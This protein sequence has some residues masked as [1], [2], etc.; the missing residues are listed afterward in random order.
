MLG[1]KTFQHGAMKGNSDIPPRRP[2]VTALKVVFWIVLGMAL[3]FAGLIVCIVRTLTPERLTPL[4]EEVANRTLDAY[5]EVDRVE[6]SFRNSYPFVDLDMTDISVLSKA[7]VNLPAEQHKYL[8]EW[9]D[10]LLT[11]GHVH[12]GINPFRLYDDI[13]DLHDLLIDRPQVNVLVVDTVLNNFSLISGSDD[14]SRKLTELPDIRLN[15]FRLVS[16][17]LIRYADMAQHTEINAEIVD[18]SLTNDSDKDSYLPQYHVDFGSEIDSPL[19]GIIGQRRIRVALDGTV[20]WRHDHPYQI[21]LRDFDIAVYRLS[22][23]LDTSIDFRNNMIIKEFDLLINPLAVNDILG[24]IPAEYAEEKKIPRRLD[25]DATVQAR[26][27]LLK[28]YTIGSVLLPWADV[29]VEIPDCHLKYDNMDFRKVALSLGIALRGSTPN[30]AVFDIRRLTVEG[31]HADLTVN[32]RVTDIMR[33]PRVEGEIKGSADVAALP[34]SL[35]SKIQAIVQ[36]SVRI[37][38]RLDARVS[39]FSAE[40]FHKIHI[41][42]DASVDRFYFQAYDTL[43]FYKLHKAS[44]RFGS[45]D[46]STLR[47][48]ADIDTA[49]MLVSG[50]NFRMGHVS[51]NAAAE[52]Y[53]ALSDK[54]AKPPVRARLNVGNFS[55]FTISDTLGARMADISG[56]ITMLRPGANPRLPRIALDMKLGQ[57]SSGNNRMRLVFGDGRLDCDMALLPRGGGRN[58]SPKAGK[59]VAAGPHR[60]M[61]T[62]SVIKFARAIRARH[63]SPFPRVHPVITGKDTEVI[64]FGASKLI[65][66]MLLNWKIR[67]QL[68]T[69]IARVFTPAFPVRN[70]IKSLAVKFDNDTISLN[71]IECRAGRSDFLVSGV[72]TNLKQGLTSMSSPDPLKINFEIKSDHIDIN[73]FAGAFFTGATARDKKMNPKAGDDELRVELD[74]EM[75]LPRD[76]VAPFLVPTN[77]DAR[78]GITA[79]K[80]DYSDMQLHDFTGLVLMSGGSINLHDCKASLAAGSVTLDALYSASTPDDMNFGFGLD[81]KDF[82]IHNFLKMMPPVDSLM[83]VMRD[84]SGV[85]NAQVAATTKITPAMKI[86]M[87]TMKAAVR[88]EGDSIVFLSEETYRE[89][90][91]WLLFKHK[92]ENMV[93]HVNVEMLIDDGS[94]RLYPFIFDFN[95]YRLGIEGYTDIDLQMHYHV[96]VLKSPIPFKFGVNLNGPYDHLKIRFG[97]AHFDEKQ[98]TERRPAVSDMRRSLIDDIQRRFTL[99][100]RDSEFARLHV[101][102]LPRAGFISL[103]TDTLSAADSLYLMR[104][105]FIPQ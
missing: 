86:D 51:L 12:G 52:D 37:D 95:R 33:D 68:N 28:P 50:L 3:A 85:V 96:A 23:H 36:G 94:L 8:P 27:H 64:D 87:P 43:S 73:E 82:N 89:V 57:V 61:P 101:G 49:Q 74:E 22:G 11:I 47:V 4:V 7:I 21:S 83:P 45:A 2:W 29:E 78:F 103:E 48:A 90:A 58:E 92:D 91:K 20:E 9:A 66:N 31:P 63:H 46:D 44:L 93:R 100:E 55:L 42:G 40:D 60:V 104:E 102:E 15:R 17:R 6:L 77:V 24:F 105:G 53:R 30:E 84:L 62:D 65:R 81:I 76:S 19:F 59:K 26:M 80:I 14:S 67:G 71:D 34:R 88:I 10:T 16:P 25:T 5:V 70:G 38:T 98:V 69:G 39:M 18:A 97:G 75:H 72:I 56:N 79:G 41:D 35:I 1:L 13:I 32:C 54:M 99:G